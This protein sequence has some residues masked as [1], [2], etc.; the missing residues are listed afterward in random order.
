MKELN[1]KILWLTT[2]VLWLFVGSYVLY[3]VR[4]HWGYVHG[5]RDSRGNREIKRQDK[6]LLAAG[7]LMLLTAAWNFWRVFATK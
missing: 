5:L 1:P 6:L 3:S 7:V 4:K 2:G